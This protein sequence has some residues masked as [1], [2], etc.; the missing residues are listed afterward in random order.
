MR[1]L[2]SSGFSLVELILFLVILM[3]IGGAG[4]FVYTSKNQTQKTLDTT[5]KAQNDA[6]KSETKYEITALPESETAG[7][8]EY[9]A[10]AYSIKFADGWKIMKKQGSNDSFTAAENNSLKP[11]PGKTA[12]V[13]E[14]KQSGP[15][16]LIYGLY[17]DYE[18]DSTDRCG[19][20][21]DNKMVFK[22][23]HG[24]DVYRTV[25]KGPGANLVEGDKN[26]YYCVQ[27]SSNSRLNVSYTISG[28]MEDYSTSVE[29][30]LLTVTP[31][32]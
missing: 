8:L 4:Y 18:K 22:T 9:K 17:I 25:T 7:W 14:Y 29:Q 20:S 27:L 6:Q 1:K 2:T 28:S 30:V 5:S 12:V 16:E 10:P 19:N 13:E 21:Q 11:T 3:M 31:I 15:G 23:K 24:E 32:Q 26:Y